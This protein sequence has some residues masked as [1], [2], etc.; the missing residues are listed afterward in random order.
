MT[1][2][3]FCHEEHRKNIS[4]KSSLELLLRD[5]SYALLWMLLCGVVDQDVDFAKFSPGS[6]HRIFAKLF[7]ANITGQQ[8]T[9]AAFGFDQ[10]LRFPGIAVL[11]QLN[12]RNICTL[13]G[14]KDRNST[15]TS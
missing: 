8:Q 7:T 11:G 15:P 1:H 14:E 13:L 4:A 10:P 12:D 6:L 5:L 3:G 2:R 9:F